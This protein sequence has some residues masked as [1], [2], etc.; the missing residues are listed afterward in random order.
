MVVV[1]RDPQPFNWMEFALNM[2][3]IVSKLAT[4]AASLAIIG[5]LGGHNSSS[6]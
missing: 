4:T 1:P 3:D 6:N 2:S 5:S